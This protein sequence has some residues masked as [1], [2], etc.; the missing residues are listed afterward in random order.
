MG[1]GMIPLESRMIVELQTK[2]VDF[3]FLFSL[4]GRNLLRFFELPT[5]HKFCQ[6]QDQH[7]LRYFPMKCPLGR[8]KRMDRQ[9]LKR[10]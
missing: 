2:T 7:I 8:S 1:T 9:N 4:E 6:K 10:R 3:N 5:E